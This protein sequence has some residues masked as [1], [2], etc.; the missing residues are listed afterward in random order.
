VSGEAVLSPEESNFLK[1]ISQNPNIFVTKIYKALQLS[2][3]KGDKLKESLIEKGLIVQEETRRGVG[4]RLANIL[5]LTDKGA[6]VIKESSPAGK[7]GDSHKHL[8]QMLKEQAGL[9]GW[10]A[11]I[12][13]RIPRSLES[14]DVGLMKDDVRVAIE[15]SSTSKPDQEIQ[16][17]RKC[18]DAG[19]DYVISVSADEKSL[20]LIKK[21]T[22]KNFTLRERER[23]KFSSPEKA[24]EFLSRIASPSIVSEKGIVSGL[25]SREK[26][27]INISEASEL[28]GIRK[29]TLYEWVVQ[30]KI[31]YIKVGRLVKFRKEDL[32]AW[33]AK[34]LQEEKKDIAP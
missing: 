32:E 34:R 25:I 3:Y 22:K 11:V 12:E 28:L 18:L 10:K 15:I 5:I 7:G 21:E 6:S 27:L 9:F 31:P 30:R 13:E 16:N 29:N 23:I 33:I 20:S 4:G 2:G 14:V 1:F 8:Q 17:I 24:K 19:Y 26:Q